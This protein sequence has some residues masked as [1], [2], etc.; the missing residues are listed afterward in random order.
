M[1]ASLAAE[2]ASFMISMPGGAPQA[3]L[4]YAKENDQIAMSDALIFLESEHKQYLN[5]LEH[6]GAL[7]AHLRIFSTVTRESPM[8]VR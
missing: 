8:L 7:A 2:H 3:L 1:V 6:D 5:A 4:D